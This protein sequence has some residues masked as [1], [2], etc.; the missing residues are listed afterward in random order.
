[1]VIASVMASIVSAAERL[2]CR[3]VRSAASSQVSAGS[4]D[5]DQAAQVMVTLGW[6]TD[7]TG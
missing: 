4:H 7:T 2:A 5:D 6:R 3:R 1:M